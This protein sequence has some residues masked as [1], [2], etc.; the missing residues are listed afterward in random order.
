MLSSG[1]PNKAG[2]LTQ[3]SPLGSSKLA[4]QLIGP[5]L[6][7]PKAARQAYE[8][9]IKAVAGCLGGEPSSAEIQEAAVSIWDALQDGP[10]PAKLQQGR[11]SVSAAVKPYRYKQVIPVTVRSQ[12]MELLT[13]TD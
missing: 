12:D 13:L 7:A 9:Y 1:N 3:T 10:P 5:W 11:T 2:C 8:Q 4:Q 6:K